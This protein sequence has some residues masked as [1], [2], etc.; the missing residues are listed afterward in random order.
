MPTELDIT[1]RGVLAGSTIPA[2]TTSRVLYRDGVP[3]AKLVAGEV[4]L[5]E[6]MDEPTEA[7][8]RA[9]LVRGPDRDA[10]LAIAYAPETDSAGT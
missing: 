5:L 7:L 10:D 9:K 1:R 3:V 8:A 6:P 4:T 2:L